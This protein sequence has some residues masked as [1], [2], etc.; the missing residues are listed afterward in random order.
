MLP[1]Q[2]TLASLLLLTKASG[3]GNNG[4][5][6]IAYIMVLQASCFICHKGKYSVPK[7]TRSYLRLSMLL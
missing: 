4:C 2:I 1:L 7:L 6:V 5:V 3:I